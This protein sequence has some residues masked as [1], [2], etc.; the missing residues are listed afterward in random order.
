MAQKLIRGNFIISKINTTT[1]IYWFLLGWLALNLLQSAFTELAH[2]EA[3]YW[4]YSRQLAWGYFDHPPMVALLIKIGYS[5][6]N[7]EFGVRL[8][9][10]FMGAAT[11]FILYKLI[12]AY[13]RNLRLFI[14]MVV[15]LAFFHTH[16]GGFLAIPDI[17]LVFFT[18]LFFRVFKSY[19]QNDSWQSALLLGIIASCMVYSKYHAV[20]V[21]FFT[22][23]SNL[24]LFKRW[25]FWIIPF[26][27]IIS[28]L[29]HLFWQIEQGFPTF[30]YHLVSR[31][32]AY[33]IQHTLNYLGVQLLLSGP[34]IALPLLFFGFKQSASSSF[35][36]AMQFNMFG[37]FGF[38]LLMSFR[39]HI[40][41]HWT[42]V[43][44]IPLFI[45]GYKGIVDQAK[46]VKIIRW[47]ALPSI[48]FVVA[49]RFALVFSV[50]PAS[51]PLG[52]EFHRWEAWSQQIDSI[53]DGRKVVFANT[54]QRPAKYS[55]YTHGKFAH[56]LNNIYYRKN[57]Y[58]IWPFEDSLQHQKVVMF[59][60]YKAPY[61]LNSV[62]G[63]SYYYQYFDDFISY[64]Q[65]KAELSTRRPID[66]MYDS[67]DIKVV[68]WNPTIDTVE[69]RTDSIYRAFLS[70]VI[71]RDGQFIKRQQVFNMPASK[72]S[73][74]DS[75]VVNIQLPMPEDKGKYNYFIGV[76]TPHLYQGFT[77]R[78]LVLEIK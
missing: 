9:F 58:D 52:R 36:R 33:T 66:R 2:D 56:S 37:F 68:V 35:E 71:T 46:A 20:L 74:A 55:F 25:S 27:L 34:F 17:P 22:L 10:V 30:E 53:A 6:L 63:E 39:G 43:A 38:F 24:K 15:S 40:E 3:Y 13:P 72:L 57:Q 4:V 64:N 32:S 19:L 41:G 31:S 76:A 54:F 59:G 61:E 70:A 18:I 42:A 21:L 5:F 78:P 62:V 69:F 45:L 75:M 14:L 65:L 48:L 11:I 67:I 44:F 1:S 29:P 8:L 7:N 16:I 50:L 28:M 51:S 12:E 73:P 49:I 77:C 47:L 60:F 26:V 23:I